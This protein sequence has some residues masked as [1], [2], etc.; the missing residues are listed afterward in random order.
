MYSE[1][2]VGAEQPER[3]EFNTSTVLEK[4]FKALPRHFKF[5]QAFVFCFFIFF[6]CQSLGT[7]TRYAESKSCWIHY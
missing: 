1:H 5:G 3:F 6:G 7:N 2:L 4:A